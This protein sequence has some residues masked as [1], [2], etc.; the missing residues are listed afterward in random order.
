MLTDRARDTDRDRAYW[1]LLKAIDASRPVAAKA[2]VLRK[3]LEAAT[4]RFTDLELLRAIDF[5]EKAGLVT[6][7]ENEE[8]E[9]VVVELTAD[10]IRF[11]N[12]SM[13]SIV[14]IDRPPRRR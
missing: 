6:K 10:G 3:V 14:G 8:I 11:V 9:E 2:S 13:P 5:L 12:Y 1:Y 4:Y 7:A